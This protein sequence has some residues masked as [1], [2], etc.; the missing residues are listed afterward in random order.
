VGAAGEYPLDPIAAP[1]D[2]LGACRDATFT[3]KRL[4]AVEV[5]AARIEPPKTLVPGEEARMGR[6]VERDVEDADGRGLR[7]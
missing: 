2:T 3:E 5:G 6:A 1:H 4:R 7:P